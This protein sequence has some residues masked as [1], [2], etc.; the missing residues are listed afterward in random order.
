M[1]IPGK[2]KKK[3]KSQ[4]AKYNSCRGYESQCAPTPIYSTTKWPA[5]LPTSVYF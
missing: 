1:E 4:K 5:F 2:K 3:M